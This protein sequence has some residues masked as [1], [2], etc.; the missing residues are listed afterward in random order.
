MRNTDCVEVY[1]NILGLHCLHVYDMVMK[2]L[3]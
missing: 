2:M 1:T 3:Y